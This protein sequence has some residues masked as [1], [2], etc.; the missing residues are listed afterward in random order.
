VDI[1]ARRTGLVCHGVI[2]WFEDARA[3]PAEDAVALDR[4]PTAKEGAIHIAVPRL[5]RIANFDDLD[6]LAAEP[7]VAIDIVEPGR[8]LPAEA[9][10][11][12]L[13][14]SK[15]TIADLAVLRGEGWDIDLKAHLRRGRPI[16]G[17]CA[18]YQM[19][20]ARLEDP[21][22]AEG[23]AGAVDGLGLLEVETVLTGDKRLVEAAGRERA[24]GQPVRGYEMHI[25]KTTGPALA[26]PMMEIGG[27]PD[28]AVSPDGLVAGCYL[29]GLF[30]SDEFRRAFLARLRDGRPQAEAYEA[31]VETTLDALAEHLE[32][33]CDLDAL[34]AIA[35]RGV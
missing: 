28:G 11:I 19:L 35:E 9:D 10:L 14:G 4:R 33:N 24:T 18:G 8:P 25:G 13:P 31:K 32:A 17:L 26:R 16:I 7:D 22:G 21:N 3:L 34:L 12:L 1:I 20:G 30:A 5:S 23:P 2:P 6:P 15:S 27:H 29:H